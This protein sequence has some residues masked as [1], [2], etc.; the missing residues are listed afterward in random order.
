MKI[1]NLKRVENAGSLI[2]R[3][4]IEFKPLIVRGMSL[5]LRD[6]G[7]MFISEPAEKYERRDNGQ[8]AWHKHVVITDD[9]LRGH[10]AKQV[11]ELMDFSGSD[12]EIPF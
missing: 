8:T 9:E 5:F 1:T 3:F 6:N 4:D 12:E 2:A 7:G 11:K 10:I